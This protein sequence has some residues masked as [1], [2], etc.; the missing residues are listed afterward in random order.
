MDLGVY[1]IYW[2]V[3]REG[4]KQK[5]KVERAKRGLVPRK[6]SQGLTEGGACRVVPP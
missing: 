3:L 5:G 6:S 2:G 4:G 1:V